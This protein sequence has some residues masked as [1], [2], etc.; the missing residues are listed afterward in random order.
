MRYLRPFSTLA[1][2]I[3]IGVVVVPRIRGAV[4]A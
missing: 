3:V 1:V 4:G 2:G